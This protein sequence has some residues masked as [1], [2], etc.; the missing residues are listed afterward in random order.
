MM[1]STIAFSMNGDI[2]LVNWWAKAQ[3]A[4]YGKASVKYLIVS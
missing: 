4:I 1:K 2:N 3:C